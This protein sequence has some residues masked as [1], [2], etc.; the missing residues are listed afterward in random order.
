MY[1]VFLFREEFSFSSTMSCIGGKTWLSTQTL[2]SP[3]LLVCFLTQT[4]GSIALAQCYITLAIGFA[5]V[6]PKTRA[7]FATY[8]L[9]SANTELPLAN[10]KFLC[11]SHALHTWIMWYFHESCPRFRKPNV[12]LAINKCFVSRA[13]FS[14]EKSASFCE[15]CT[16]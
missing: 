4:T 1:A 9:L 10:K 16:F 14:Y 11:P 8:V 12:S 6:P 3:K 13:T 7:S 15:S 5:S 2:Y